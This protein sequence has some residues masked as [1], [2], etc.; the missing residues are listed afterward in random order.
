MAVIIGLSD[1]NTVMVDLDNM[2]FKRVKRLAELT[3]KHFRLGGFII[4]K[5]SPNHYHVIFDKPIRYWSEVLRIISWIA[6]M[7]NNPHVWKWVCMQAIKKACTLRVSE[8]PA[9][10]GVKPKPRI[11]YRYGSQSRKI[12]AYLE[13]RKEV[14][15]IFRE[16]IKMNNK[17]GILGFWQ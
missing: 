10:N 15:D 8:K 9:K 11:V 14:N 13:K 1:K 5:S 12:N 16:L 17:Y 4:L 2:S 3:C 6:I 7:S